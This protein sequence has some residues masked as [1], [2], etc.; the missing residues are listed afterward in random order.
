MRRSTMATALFAVFIS[1][2]G[3]PAAVKADGY[4]KT[5]LVSDRP[6]SSIS[7]LEALGR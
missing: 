5:D 6:V 4:I 1:Y 3:I 7:I 2:L